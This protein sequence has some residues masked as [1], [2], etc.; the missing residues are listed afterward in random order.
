MYPIRAYH[1]LLDPHF[2]AWMLLSDTKDAD[3]ESR[4]ARMPKLNREQRFAW[5]IPLPTLI[6]QRRLVASLADRI[7]GTERVRRTVEVELAVIEEV[8]AALLRQA[9]SGQR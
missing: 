5:R 9:F 3:E 6:E 8:P 7:A 4:R 1:S 2:L